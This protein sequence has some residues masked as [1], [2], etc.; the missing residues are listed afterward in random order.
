MLRAALRKLGATAAARARALAASYD[1]ALTARPRLTKAL[2]AA[3][4]AAAGDLVA[5]LLAKGGG[6][7]GGGGGGYDG[8]GSGSGGSGSGGGGGGVSGGSG[9]LLLAPPEDSAPPPAIDAFRTAKIASFQL[10]MAP[11][12]HQ[13]FGLLAA[14]ALS[15][16]VSMALDQAVFAPL[17]AAAFLGYVAL[18]ERYPSPAHFVLDK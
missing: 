2:T 12:V 13:W 1:D 18:T 6:G 9:A 14:R 15:P 8:G 7:G 3:A 17:G 11:L 5:Q 10:M 16:L 4:I